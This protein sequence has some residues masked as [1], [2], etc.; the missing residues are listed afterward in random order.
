ML[1]LMSVVEPAAVGRLFFLPQK[2]CLVEFRDGGRASGFDVGHFDHGKIRRIVGFEI[3]AAG[4]ADG[5][6]GVFIV[7][8]LPRA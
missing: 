4:D 6:G 7:A 3:K 1:R 8:P 5:A 2:F